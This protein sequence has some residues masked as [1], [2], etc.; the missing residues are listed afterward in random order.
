[1]RMLSATLGRYACHGTLDNFQ[2]CLLYALTGYITGNGDVF[3]LLRDLI[4]LVDIYDTVLGTF[5]IVVRRLDQ[6][7]Q[8]ILYIFAYITGL[9]QC[10]GICDS[11]R[12][13][14]DL[15]QCLRQV[16][17]T[18]T[19]RSYHDDITLLQLHIIQ[20]LGSRYSLVMI[21][22]R[23]GEDLFRLLLPDDIFIQE[24][25]DLLRF[26]KVDIRSRG[27]FHF[28]VFQF[29]LQDVSADIYA[30][31]TDIYPGRSCDQLADLALGLVTK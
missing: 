5:H 10:G 4:D 11:K 3:T 30:L 20:I 7:Q 21:V 27:L 8:N 25:L 16:S 17:L 14:D 26:Q 12:Y 22:H 2:Q 9:S 29:L 1:M 24:V 6:L 31:I 15:R 19:G 23:N 13:I 18:G 28:F